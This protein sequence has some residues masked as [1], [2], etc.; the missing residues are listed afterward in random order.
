M[1]AATTRDRI[2]EALKAVLVRDGSTA[3]TLEAVAAEAGVSKGGLLYHFRSKEALLDGLLQQLDGESLALLERAADEPQGAARVYLEASIPES[4]E[5]RALHWSI[6]AALR[7][8]DGSE[9][10]STR[11]LREVFDRW[12]RRLRAAIE[13]PV[14]AEMV[15]L[16]GD[17]IFLNAML[18]IPPA[19]PAVHRAVI[20]RLMAALPDRPPAD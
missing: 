19:D 6:L 14:M 3:V 8:A 4:D 1:T 17:G 20:E 11:A 16:V 15:R 5:E 10:A 18:G 12:G 13:D 2:L 7:A 9:G